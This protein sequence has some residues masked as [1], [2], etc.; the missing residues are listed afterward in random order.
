MAPKNVGAF[1]FIV[2]ARQPVKKWTTTLSYQVR[3]TYNSSYF[4]SYFPVKIGKKKKNTYT[5]SHFGDSGNL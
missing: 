4:S 3:N 2:P 1:R 5:S